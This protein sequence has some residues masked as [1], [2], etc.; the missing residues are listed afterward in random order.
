MRET[1][2]DRRQVLKALAAAPLAA[3]LRVPGRRAEKPNLLFLW[4]DQQRPDTMRVYGNDRI[5][6]PNFNRFADECAVFEHAY[7]TQPICTPSRSTVLSGLW[8]HTNGCTTNG[9]RLQES[10]RALPELL[11]DD[12]YRTGYFGKWH[13][14]DELFAQHGFEEW[15]SIEDGYA[16]AYGPGRDRKQ[17][18]DY[19][20]YLRDRGYEPDLPSD[21]FS[22]DFASRLPIE[23][24]K[25]RFLEERATD[26]L[27]RHRDEPFLLHVNFLEPH[28]PYWGPLNDE[29][30]AGEMELPA[31]Y[32]V[33]LGADDPLAYRIR[34]ITDRRLRPHG[35]DLSTDAGWQQLMANYWGNVTCIDRAV[36]GILR[37]LEELGLAD[38]TIVVYTADHGDM[39]GAHSMCR[40][41]VMYEQAVKVPLLVRAPS[42]GKKQKIVRGRVSQI[43]LVP[44]LLD[45]MG[46]PV[47]GE[48]PGRS[49][50]P[51]M[52]RGRAEAPVFVEWHP[53]RAGI[54]EDGAEARPD[55]PKGESDRTEEMSRVLAEAGA[56]SPEVAQRAIRANTRAV[57]SPEGW[58]LC[59]S[60]GDRHQ[61]F[62]LERDPEEM[63]NLFHGGF[64]DDVVR[65]LT[66]ELHRWQER[67]KD[68]VTVEPT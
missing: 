52:G 25:P 8:P 19:D 34:R 66:R 42:L 29:H 50:L 6:A 20:R 17:R 60:D 38:N 26:F 4:A 32:S 41:E 21:R 33:P 3:G 57:I 61:L 16:S 22:R 46:K 10:T 36:G 56:A 62:H 43:D 39:M 55:A 5:H 7:V 45:L 63:H 51:A 48:L 13:L 49:L 65:R 59:L 44:T 12:D 67:V 35:I 53:G 11:A 37:S 14:G 64:H 27:K 18:S 31:S 23:H 24:G 1:P 40:K 15:Q 9:I 28:P 58:K 2:L 47:P 30:A 54:G 68:P